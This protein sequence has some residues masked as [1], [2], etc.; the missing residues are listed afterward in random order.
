M[1]SAKSS[2]GFCLKSADWLFNSETIKLRNNQDLIEYRSI[3]ANSMTHE[4]LKD[5]ISDFCFALT[6]KKYS[7]NS[8]TNPEFWIAFIQIATWIS[9]IPL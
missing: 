9:F 1:N 8:D 2:V 5:S 7:V 6:K 3:Q 4:L